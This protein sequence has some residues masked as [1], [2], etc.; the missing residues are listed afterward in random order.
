MRIVE[1]MDRDKC[2]VLVHCSDGWDRTAQ[3][4]SI[5]QLV[6]DPFFRTV[7]CFVQN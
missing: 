6:M 2:S 3:C 7:V 5:A 4:C 1:V